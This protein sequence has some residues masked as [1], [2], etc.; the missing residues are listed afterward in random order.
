MKKVVSIMLLVV[1][2][3][4]LSACGNKEVVSEKEKD[5]SKSKDV[6][7]ESDSKSEV[8]EQEEEKNE[9]KEN[10]SSE[11]KDP[12]S[13]K[14]AH[15]HSFSSATCTSPQ[16][17]SCG[18]TNGSALGHRWQEATCETPK[19]CSVCG[20]I[21]GSV[22]SHK[23]V[24]GVCAYC[25]NKQ[26]ISP[27]DG[28]KLN[29]DYYYISDEEDGNFSL[30]IYRFSDSTLIPRMMYSTNVERKDGEETINYDG[31]LWYQIGFGYTSLPEYT[32]TDTEIIVKYFGAE[33]R[34]SVNYAYDLVVT[35]S[36]GYLFKQGTILDLVE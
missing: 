20:A 9:E 6:V 19:K 27:K 14:P 36:G 30:S 26:I 33:Y 34:L 18:A 23:Y 4:L 35:S 16:K 5:V 21:E 15:V 8:V 17:C 11:S 32:L 31:K 3:L 22:G 29:A 13:S 28:L 7:V 25:G 2:S 1:A 12:E 10:K 24:S